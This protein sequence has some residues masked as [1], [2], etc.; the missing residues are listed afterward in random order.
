MHIEK[1]TG[2][3]EIITSM[4]LRD[5][6]TLLTAVLAIAAAFFMYDRRIAVLEESK[7]RDEAQIVQLDSQIK[8]YESQR[9]QDRQAIESELAAKEAE[10]AEMKTDIAVNRVNSEVALHLRKKAQ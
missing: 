8:S 4:S 9:Y 6:L 10:I 1:T 2:K 5:V 7:T 3:R